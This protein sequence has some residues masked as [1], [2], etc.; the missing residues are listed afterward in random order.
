M[1]GIQARALIALGSA[2]VLTA[3]GT[4]TDQP[5]T[6]AGGGQKVTY[7]GKESIPKAGRAPVDPLHRR[8]RMAGEGQGGRPRRHRHG[9]ARCR[10]SPRP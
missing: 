5:K 6:G 1:N 4:K 2:L 3:C 10:P 7:L 8:R 9:T